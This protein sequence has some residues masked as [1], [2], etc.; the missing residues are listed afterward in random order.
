MFCMENG[1]Q[2][3]IATHSI[4]YNRLPKIFLA[5]D[6]YDRLTTSFLDRESVARVLEGTGIPMVPLISVR[7]TMP[8]RLE[9]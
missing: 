2:Q 8:T 9:L 1:W 5:F 7:N 4:P 3:P 6:L